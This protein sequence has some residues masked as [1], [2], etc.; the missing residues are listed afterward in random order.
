MWDNYPQWNLTPT[1]KITLTLNPNPSR[2]QFSSGA[3]DWL[4]LNPKTKPNLDPNHNPNR[5]TILLV[6]QLS[7]FCLYN[8]YT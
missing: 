1:P 6:G 7:G 8:P 3:I 2:G 4:L 5:R